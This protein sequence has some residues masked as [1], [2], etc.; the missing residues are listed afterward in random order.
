MNSDYNKIEEDGKI[1]GH[2]KRFMGSLLK[3]KIYRK[4]IFGEKEM[5]AISRDLVTTRWI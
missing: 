4:E 1:H 2:N 5:P 3:E